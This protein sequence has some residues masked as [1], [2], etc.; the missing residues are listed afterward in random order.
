[1][2]N[3]LQ[4]ILLST[5]NPGFLSLR[6]YILGGAVSKHRG[7]FAA[8]KKSAL[9]GQFG[10]AVQVDI[11][12]TLGVESAWFRPFEIKVLS[13]FR[14][15]LSTCT[16][17]VRRGAGAPPLGAAAVAGA[18]QERQLA[19]GAS[20]DVDA[21][22]AAKSGAAPVLEQ[23]C[24]GGRDALICVLYNLFFF[25]LLFVCVSYN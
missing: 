4:Q 6:H 2:F 18:A 1:M 22:A 20:A 13:T 9:R 10:R 5:L 21:P 19:A 23:Q 14:F 11:R 7:P 25:L 15:Q 8:S 3:L 17:I 12:L 24:Q 16:P